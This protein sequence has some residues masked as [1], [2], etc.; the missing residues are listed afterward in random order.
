[1]LF[2]SP[3]VVEAL[4]KRGARLEAINK[5]KRTPLEELCVHEQV[6]YSQ[7]DAQNVPIE[8]F[9][10]S[11]SRLAIL[12]LLISHKAKL[13]S[14]C[15]QSIAKWN[16]AEFSSKLNSK[17][18]WRSISELAWDNVQAVGAG[19]VTIGSVAIVA[20]RVMR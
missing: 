3:G 14:K 2:A 4:L 15:R 18:P 11:E 8:P 17:L 19:L 7:A 5:G 9:R 20:N 1:V 12:Q 16:N 10:L 6:W 13:S